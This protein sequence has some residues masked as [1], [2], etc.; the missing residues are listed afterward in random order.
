VLYVGLGVSAAV[1]GTLFIRVL[2]GLEDVADHVWTGPEWLRPAVGGLLLGGLLLVLPQLYGVGYPVLGHAVSGGYAVWFLI[3]LLAGKLAAT[4]LTIAIGG[5]GGVFAPSLFMGAM[6]GT[7]YGD[8]VSGVAPHLAGPAGAYGLVGM[9]AV[10]AGAARAPI[11][12]VLIIFELTGDY[13]IILP[14][15]VSVVIATAVASLLGGDSIYTLKLRRRG[16]DLRRAHPSTLE[17]LSVADTMQPAPTPVRPED[18]LAALVER[19]S[20]GE[21]VTLPLTAS[22]ATYAGAISSRDVQLATRDGH[23]G[24]LAADLAHELPT[25]RPTQRLDRALDDLV[26]ADGGGLPVVSDNGL[27]VGWITHS[28]VLRAYHAHLHS[29]GAPHPLWDR[30]TAHGSRERMSEHVRRTRRRDTTAQ[31]RRDELTGAGADGDGR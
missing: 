13:H 8:A 21:A 10:F 18:E 17:G 27:L 3:G 26:R 24:A 11:T 7:A 6:L 20:D 22:D 19:F 9:G 23:L 30:P 2:Y 4:S 29:I 28:D 25:L 1:L 15:M 14:L 31:A 12:A 16:I 5:S